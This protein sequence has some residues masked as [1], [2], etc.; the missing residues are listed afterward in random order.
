MEGLATVGHDPSI[1][2]LA[3]L[4]PALHPVSVVAVVHVVDDLIRAGG[5]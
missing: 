2:I 4:L 3:I 5:L 1:A